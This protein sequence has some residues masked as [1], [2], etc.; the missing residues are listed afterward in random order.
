MN[1]FLLK[2]P[3]DIRSDYNGYDYFIEII[4]IAK[5]LE[6]KE[7]LIDF[8]AVSF[9]EANLA[10]LFGVCL[11]ILQFNKN[12]F[13]IINLNNNVETIL[14]KNYFL[15]EL[16]Y[17]TITDS[18]A[19]SLRYMKFQPND[20]EGFN[21]Y[22]KEQLLA[23][24]DFPLV[25]EQLKKEIIKNIFEIY[26]NARTHGKCDYIHTCGQFFPRQTN[27]PFHFTLVD[28]GINIKE[29]VSA[30]KK[31]DIEA[32]DA[33]EWAMIKGNTT[34]TQTSGGL[35]LAVIFEFI[36]LNRGKIQIVSADGYYEY[37][38]EIITKRRINSY[39]DGT[40]VTIIF[41]F[42]DKNYYSLLSEKL[43]LK[44]AF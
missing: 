40:I 16:N 3:K 18:Y 13:K 24:S 10:A 22:I 2:F 39:F 44:N 1:T 19:T 25:S 32:S 41:N 20:D 29:N 14:R 7:V 5:K 11:E 43:D 33:I 31:E 37:K 34:K 12:S 26:E 28:K 8:A 23:K 9:F 30:F 42:N 15:V 17:D 6:S 35:G 27:M 21:K 36:K 38:N 4:N